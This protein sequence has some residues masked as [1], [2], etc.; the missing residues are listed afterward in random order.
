MNY[1]QKK[2]QLAQDFGVLK[3]QNAARSAATN[4]VD[5]DGVT[6][7]AGRGARDEGIRAK[8]E[9]MEKERLESKKYGENSS[10]FKRK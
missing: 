7:A 1:P 6:N 4:K 3:S 8:A 2:A 9:L 5:D 10:L